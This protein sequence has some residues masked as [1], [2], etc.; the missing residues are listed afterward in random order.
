MRVA[1]NTFAYIHTR[2]F[3]YKKEEMRFKNARHVE[4]SLA[5]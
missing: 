1:R 4:N 3:F 5:K 2:E